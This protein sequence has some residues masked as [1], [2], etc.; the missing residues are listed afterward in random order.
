MSDNPVH[1]GQFKATQEAA[2]SLGVDVQPVMTRS[3][4]ELEQA[5][6]SFAREKI[7]SIIVLGG[8]GRHSE[9][10]PDL[11]ARAKLPAVYSDREFVTRGGLLSYS[12]RYGEMYK[13][14]AAYVDKVLKGAKPADLPIEQPTLFRG[15]Q[16][17][18]GEATGHH[19]SL[20]HAHQCRG[21][22]LT[23]GARTSASGEH[24]TA[25]LGARSGHRPS[26]SLTPHGH[27]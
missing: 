15:N 10:I 21:H 13:T 23:S 1:S 19:H 7:G 5:F 4:A 2:G 24:R 8:L 11:A 17:E 20:I 6:S 14:V 9:K 26:P 18:S 12:P 16:R 25:A 22:P 27:C 3:E